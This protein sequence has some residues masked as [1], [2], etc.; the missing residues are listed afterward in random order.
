MKQAIHSQ[1][2]DRYGLQQ[3]HLPKQEA[4]DTRQI[5]NNQSFLSWGS[6]NVVSFDYHL[7]NYTSQSEVVQ[8]CFCSFNIKKDFASSK[9]RRSK[10]P[11]KF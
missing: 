3:E 2:L 11:C 10:V 4:E 6:L 1:G 9:T 5:R 8:E 7:E